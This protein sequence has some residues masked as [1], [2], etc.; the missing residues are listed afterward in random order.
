VND[1]PIEAHQ[2]R[3][4]WKVVALAAVFL[5]LALAAPLLIIERL[6]PPANTLFWKTFFDAGH[7]ILFGVQAVVVLVVLK[8]ALGRA[9]PSRWHYWVAFAVALGVGATGEV[10]QIGTFRSAS[11]ADFLRDACGALSF[12]LIAA[13]LDGSTP[14]RH[15]GLT[16]VGALL[17]LAIVF[18]PVG[19][20]T[21]GYLHRSKTFPVIL[22]WSV[23]WQ[24]PFVETRRARWWLLESPPSES[25][26]AS[27]LTR[28]NEG[29]HELDRPIATFEFSTGSY[30]RFTI[31]EPYPDWRGFDR[32]TFGVYSS[33]S[34]TVPVLLR[35][36]DGAHNHASS[37]RYE[38]TFFV[39][40][41]FHRVVVPLTRILAGPE[42]RNLDLSDVVRF[43]VAVIEPKSPVRLS[44]SSIRLEKD[45]T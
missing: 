11:W 5:A 2:D 7:A 18:S 21:A 14:R 25:A 16:R 43:T 38:E 29:V 19:V 15:N 41:G 30:P 12:L 39:S 8:R 45:E 36:E 10:S 23:R 9:W 28:T 34:R 37:D 27:E 31:R 40:R 22:D 35:I 17:V 3:A 44:F 26:W 4:R 42:H 24:H 13:T 32:L 1:V 6:Q 20:V 33:E